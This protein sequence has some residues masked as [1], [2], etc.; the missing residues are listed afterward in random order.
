VRAASFSA[1]VFAAFVV[2]ATLIQVASSAAGDAPRGKAIYDS[3]CVECHGASGHGDGPAS[4]LLA[5]RPRDFTTGQYKL[6]T[7]ETG[8]LPTD[9]DLI[10]SVG[11]GLYGT[12]MP[13]WQSLLSDADIRDVVAYVKSLSPRFATDRPQPV[14]IID[15]PATTPESVARGAT[16]YEKLQCGKCH[17]ID[18]RGTGAVATEFEDDWK[19]PIVSANLTEPWAFRGGAAAADVYMR[20]RTGMSGTPMPSFSEAATDTEMWDLANYVVSLA[21]KPVWQMDAVEVAAFYA[22]Q[23]EDARQ[24]PVKR[25]K[26]LADSLGCALCHSPVDDE[27]RMIPG[28]KWAGGLRIRL[29]PFGDYPTGNITSDKDTGIGNWTDEEI[30]AVLTRGTLRD[31]TRLLP[32]PMDWPSFSTL[33][34]EDLNAIIAYVRT[35]PPV[36]NKVPRPSRTFLP[37]YLWGKFKMLILGQDPPMLFYTGNAGTR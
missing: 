15:R 20:F 30:R 4:F 2:F 34:S 3:H 23:E 8:T 13:A 27:K 37:I 29:E 19:Q 14:A 31:G 21:R 36:R 6:R 18:G 16:V 32:Y 7:T 5:P 11:Q 26:Y 12:S 35:I 22:G 28:M 10:R 17:G 1:A 25:G 24:H 33:K 9:D